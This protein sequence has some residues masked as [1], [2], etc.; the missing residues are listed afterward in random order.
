MRNKIIEAQMRSKWVMSKA[1][2]LLQ[3]T[4]FMI[5]GY[6]W[7]RIHL[8]GEDGDVFVEGVGRAHVS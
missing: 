1:V 2:F 8:F 5:S 3:Q 6:V 4:I 7:V